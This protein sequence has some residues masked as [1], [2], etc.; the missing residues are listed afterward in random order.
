MRAASLIRLAP[1]DTLPA[2][3]ERRDPAGERRVGE[4]T[5]LL[6]H[7]TDEVFDL[8]DHAAHC[9]RIFENALAVSLV[10]AQTLERCFLVGL[11]SDRAAGLLDRHCPLAVHQ[12]FSRASAS[13][14]PSTSPTFLPR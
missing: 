3:R 5:L 8:V 12:A 13:R 9:R 7:H 4:G 1:L 2:L 6:L 14:R 10:Q 11:A